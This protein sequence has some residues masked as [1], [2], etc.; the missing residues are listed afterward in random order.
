MNGV[1]KSE[2]TKSMAYVC[3]SY[4]SYKFLSKSYTRANL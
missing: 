4:N 1:G 3:V 2:V